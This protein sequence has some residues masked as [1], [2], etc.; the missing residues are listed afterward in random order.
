M[1]FERLVS[2][3]ILTESSSLAKHGSN[4]PPRYLYPEGLFEDYLNIYKFNDIYFGFS[5]PDRFSFNGFYG[6]NKLNS[7]KYVFDIFHD[8]VKNSY[9]MDI[10]FQ[11]K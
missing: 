10:I 7:S 1:K 11:M 4:K 2:K 8:G 9:F 3:G 6:N 5:K